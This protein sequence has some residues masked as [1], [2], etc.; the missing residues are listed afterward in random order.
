MPVSLIAGRFAAGGWFSS[1]CRISG[2][3][4]HF[5]AINRTDTRPGG[6]GVVDRRGFQSQAEQEQKKDNPVVKAR[7][8]TAARKGFLSR[9]DGASFS[10]G[11]QSH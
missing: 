11:A 3:E 4:L 7:P 10:S 9:L 6:G 2:R 5:Q 8:K 1:I